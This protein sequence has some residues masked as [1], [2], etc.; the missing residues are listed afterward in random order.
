MQGKTIGYFPYDQYQIDE[1]LYKEFDGWKQDISQINHFS[2]LPDAFKRYTQFIEE[3]TGVPIKL[4]S[5][6][7]DRKNLIQQ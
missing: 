3:Q 2:H 1:P 5:T 4:I 7:P 6:G